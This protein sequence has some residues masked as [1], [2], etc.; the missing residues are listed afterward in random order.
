MERVASG[1]VYGIKC[2]PDQTYRTLPGLGLT[3]D[4]MK[5][6]MQRVGVTEEDNLLW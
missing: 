3:M 1:M 4:V 2:L 5:A 6:D